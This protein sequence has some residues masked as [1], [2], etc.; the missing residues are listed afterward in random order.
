M[1]NISCHVFQFGSLMCYLE[2]H[3]IAYLYTDIVSFYIQLLSHER[4]RSP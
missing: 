1:S 3:K 2:L 4:F